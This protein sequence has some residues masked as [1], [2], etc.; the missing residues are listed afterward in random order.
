MLGQ[1]N[2][3]EPTPRPLMGGEADWVTEDQQLYTM[4]GNPIVL[5]DT[6]TTF[7]QNNEPIAKASFFMIYALARC[8]AQE[9]HGFAGYLR[10]YQRKKLRR[11]EVSGRKVSRL[12]AVLLNSLVAI[13]PLDE[14]NTAINE[15]LVRHIKGLAQ[16][17]CL[18]ANV[19]QFVFDIDG[20][21]S[22]SIPEGLVAALKCHKIH[23]GHI[24]P[25][26]LGETL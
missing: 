18:T 10:G 11:W 6:T 14:F 8:S 19:S 15:K 25:D 12:P 7:Q 4:P 9:L 5:L 17:K 22:Y 24:N 2:T 23:S 16:I 13:K 1:H 21:T 26:T 3:N 20:A